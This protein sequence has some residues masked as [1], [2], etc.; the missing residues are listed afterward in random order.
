MKL[1]V[2]RLG[3]EIARAE[4]P[5]KDWFESKEFCYQ[6]LEKSLKDSGVKYDS[7]EPWNPAKMFMQ[8]Q[9]N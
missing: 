2:I 1:S 7:I 4:F 6:R 3:K 5:W 8:I 9:R